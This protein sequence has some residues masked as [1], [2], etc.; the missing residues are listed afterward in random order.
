[1]WERREVNAENF[2]GIL[3]GKKP[4]GGPRSRKE[5]IRLHYILKTR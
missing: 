2:W 3:E 1:M 4:L 5:N